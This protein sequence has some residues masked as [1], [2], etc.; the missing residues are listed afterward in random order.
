MK[1]LI[2][3]II[4]FILTACLPSASQV[5]VTPEVTV[6]STPPP[7]ETPIP[8]PTSHPQ[9]TAL[10]NEIFDS[11]T[12]FT[13]QADGLIYDGETPIPGITVSPDGRM[14]LNVNGETVTLDP[15]TVSFGEEGIEVDGYELNDDGEWV[16]AVDTIMLGKVT[17]TLSEPDENG[18]Q[19]AT[20]IMVEGKYGDEEKIDELKKVDPKY[21][22][23]NPGEVEIVVKDSQIILTPTG[24]HET[25]IARWFFGT[26]DWTWHWD[27]LEKFDGGNP[28]FEF[29][30]L[31]E[32]KGV[33]EV[34]K[35]GA[36]ADDRK[37]FEFSKTDST[38]RGFGVWNQSIYLYSSDGKKVI[39]A[40]LLSKHKD[41]GGLTPEKAASGKIDGNILFIRSNGELVRMKV[42]NLVFRIRYWRY[43]DF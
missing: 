38:M 27:Q 30:K 28:V 5:T 37:I 40:I 16:E 41:A 17:L 13:L 24:E 10:Q 34:D 36:Q 18:V 21:Y 19:V 25:E 33:N 31:W 6:T 43:H 20:K 32:M 23:F 22:G 2:V 7:T 4:A 9:Y 1:K 11:S 42:D 39:G 26:N 15:D 12:R 8:M 35:E 3:F 14:S 29:G